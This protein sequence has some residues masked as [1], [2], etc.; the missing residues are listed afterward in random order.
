MRRLAANPFE[1][2]IGGLAV[3]TS[4]IGLLQPGKLATDPLDVIMPH[5]AAV[6]FL[7]G[8]LL[9]GLC[10]L[11]G[12]GAGR[13]DVEAAG[14]VI[15]AASQIARVIASVALLGASRTEVPIVFAVL[16]V[17]ACGTRLW[18]LLRASRPEV[19]VADG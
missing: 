9:S 14:L 3:A 7:L 19:E 2:L 6:T 1:V 12:V 5:W 11:A 17:G 4:L 8:Y 13:A 10:L 18:L 16:V 15:I